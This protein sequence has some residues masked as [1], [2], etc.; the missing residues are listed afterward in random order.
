[1]QS[2]SFVAPRSRG[3]DWHDGAGYDVPHIAEGRILSRI[4]VVD[5]HAVVRSG[6]ERI[7][8]R[9]GDLTLVGQ[10]GSG[11][12]A[13]SLA[14]SAGPDV[15]ILDLDMPGGGTDLIGH[16]LA[17]RPQMRILVFSQHDERDFA[18]PCLE[19]GA[20]GYLGKGE[21]TPTTIEHAIRQVASGRRYL[22]E[23]GQELAL[24]RVAGA[25]SGPAHLRLTARE[26]DIFLRIARGER[27]GRIA[28]D[29]GIS[30]KTVSTHRSKAL[31]KL[32]LAGNV[33]AAM[34]ARD[35]GL[36]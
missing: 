3:C 22:S 17:A 2:P 35:H 27:V 23:R 10:A 33:E 36:L 29:L 34:Y 9:T 8:E 15:C 11:P 12:E 20:H 30:V 28:E 16:L 18:L 4:I 7:L 21:S 14:R 24:E 26:L 6:I 13:I 5:D 1:M 31:E 25:H 19:A 32:G